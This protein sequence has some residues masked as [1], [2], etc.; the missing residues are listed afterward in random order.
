MI[1]FDVCPFMQF[2]RPIKT[3][4]SIL[5]AIVL[6]SVPGSAQQMGTRQAIS[7]PSPPVSAQSATP[8]VQTSAMANVSDTAPNSSQYVIASGDTI[9]VAVWKEPSLSSSFPVRPD[10]MISIALIGDLPAAG[11]TPMALSTDISSRLKKYINQPNVTVT[12]LSVHAKQVYVLGE[13]QHVGPVAFIS[14]MSPLQVLA[15]AGGLTPYA[16]GKK[17]YV[18]HGEPGKQQKIPFDYKKAIRDGNQQGVSLAA[19]DTIVVP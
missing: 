19:G 15:T 14:G 6:L 18:L 13:V 12:V 10:G 17:I 16:N 1:F 11:F 3:L 7:P 5:G 8:D 9:Q 2:R 4:G